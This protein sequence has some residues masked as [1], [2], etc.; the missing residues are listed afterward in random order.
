MDDNRIIKGGLPELFHKKRLAVNLNVTDICNFSCSYCINPKSK[1][2]QKRVLDKQILA[3]FLEDIAARQYEEYFLGVAGGEPL[4]YPHITFLAESVNKV[5]PGKEK[6]LLFLTNGSLLSERGEQLYAAAGDVKL[7]FTI[8]IHFEQI[9]LDSFI[10]KLVEFGHHEDLLCKVLL[11]PG[12]LEEAKTIWDAFSEN[13]IEEFVAVLTHADGQPVTYSD[14]E[15]E[16]LETRREN[17]PL[18]ISLTYEDHVEELDRIGRILHPEK[19][20]FGGMLCA[21]GISTLRLGPDGDLVR[22]L[23]F[24]RSRQGYQ[25]GERRLRDIPELLQPCRCPVPLCRCVVFQNAPKWRNPEDAPVFL[26]D[27]PVAE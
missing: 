23:A 20:S 14:A 25:L 19:L 5:L 2:K 8:S 6:T 11:A 26:K 24:Y 10:K 1:T 16:F 13:N 21:A 7:Q 27:V 15:M 22:C 9:H 18:P 3:D 4:L 17:R 12:K